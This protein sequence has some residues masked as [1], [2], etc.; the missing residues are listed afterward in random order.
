MENRILRYTLFLSTI[1]LFTFKVF[2]LPKS[3][4]TRYNFTCITM[5][6][7]LLHNFVDDIYKDKQG[8]LWISTSGGGLS[9][10]DGYEFMH[11]NIN[12]WPVSLK[13]NFIHKV[14]ED[15]FNRLWIISEKGTDVLNLSSQQL[16]HLTYKDKHFSQILN[17]PANTIL[18]DSKG[19][20]WLSAENTL[21]KIEFQQDG[22]VSNI[23]SLALRLPSSNNPLVALKEIN[24]EIWIGYNGNIYKVLANKSNQ[25][26]ISAVSDKLKLESGSYITAFFEK[27]NEVWIGT[28]HGL[29]RY[30]KTNE[31]LKRYIHSDNNPASL[32]QN[33]ITDLR[34]TTDRQL[35]VATLKGLNFYDPMNDNFMHINRD[36]KNECNSIN[37]DFINCL[38]TD[39]NLI[40][41]GT[42]A[43]G[44]NKMALRK[45]SIHNYIYNNNG[46][47]S[48]S[49]NPVNAI[50]EDNNR[51]LWVGT[52]EGGLNL[53]KKDNDKFIHF[54][55]GSSSLSHN[56]VSAI[57]ADNSNHLWIG[58][59]GGGINLL[60]LN[61][62]SH[63]TFQH[64]TSLT[65]PGFLVDFIGALCYDPINKGMWIGSNRGI[66]FY[67]TKSNKLLAPLPLKETKNI[68]GVIG[69]LIDKRNKLWM[70]TSEGAMIIDLNSFAKS[71]SHFSFRYLKYQNNKPYSHCVEK[72]NCLYESS[73]GTIWLGSNGYGLYKLISRKNE[74]YQFQSFTTTQGLTNNCVLGILEDERG[75][76]WLSTCNGLSCYNPKT[77]RF[78]NYTKEDGLISNQFYWNA[79]CKSRYNKLLYFGNI[80]GLIAIEGNKKLMTPSNEK[81]VFTKLS[82]LNETI[83]P[84]KGGYINTDISLANSLQL[85][86]SD[87]S[88]SL[89]FS[90]L[91]YENSNSITYSYRLLGFDDNW[92]K[93]S[94]NRRF[95]SYTSLRPGT[96]TLQ[97][98]CDTGSDI[99]SSNITELEIIVHPFFYKTTW[100]ICLMLVLLSFVIYRFYKWRIHTLKNQKELLHIK[101]EERTHELEEQKYLLEEQ[102]KELSRQNEMLKQ[103]NEKIT[104]QK[105]QLIKMSKKV[106]ELTLDKLTFFTNIT[107]EFRTPITL[108]MGPIERA[109]KLSYNPQVIEQLHFVERNSRHLLSLVNQLM[110][111]RKV[112]SGKIEIVKTPGNFRKFMDEILEP[113]EV[114]AHER[115]IRIEKRFRLSSPVIMFDEDAMNKVITNLLS[116]AIKYTPDKGVVTIYVS[117]LKDTETLKEKLLISVK[118]TG[119]GI[120]EEDISKIFNRFY[121]SKGSIKY[122]VYG[123]SSTGIGLYLC[124]QIV[125]LQGGIIQAKNNHTGGA[126]FRVLLPISREENGKKASEKM[127]ALP[128]PT[129][130]KQI[131]TSPEGRLNMLVVEDNKDMRSYIRSILT[132]HFNVF[133]AENGA[134]ALSILNLQNV[135]FIISD[136]MMPVMDGLELSRKVKE[137]FSISHIPFLMLTA[138]TSIE[139][140]IESFK[141]G[142]DEYLLKPFDED[143]LLARI[144][145][146]LENRKRYQK[147]FSFKMDIDILNVEEDS[148]DKKFLDKAMNLVKENFKNSYFE[149]SDFIESM[150]VSKSILN[151]K[152]QN[153]TGQSAG[154]F[155]RNYRL[156]IARELILKNRT[157]R[158]MNIS[159][160]AYEV[161]FNDPKYFTRCFTKHFIIT[162]SSLL[163]SENNSL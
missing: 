122:P 134:E 129:Q 66:Y 130:K 21:Y 153:L 68:Q 145:N 46:N 42:E 47:G 33:L 119:A 15:N 115:N 64:I 77:S 162:P 110:D 137:N 48:I 111:F 96:Y 135:D 44:L 121:Q 82:V 90:V 10:Y 138:K 136:L 80:E 84:G 91:N 100:F 81:V 86:E 37:C 52:V 159:E 75:R 83:Y 92:V 5:N 59:W 125:H 160:I 39:G 132:D 141:I 23:R 38:L 124:K 113:F 104:R 55:S 2:A 49:K 57:T 25:L 24:G 107:H 142:V 99:Q 149:V 69:S 20:I 126:S 74:E 161:G 94:S 65:H 54:T 127:T 34:E 144:N 105:G 146:I 16:N 79:Y 41:V 158:N 40:W 88:F 31:S 139:A 13:S 71:H 11:Y 116:N 14:C 22:S 143:L 60:D 133:E 72:I 76:L 58:T 102:T 12:T 151:K 148:C 109:L 114:F 51:N 9:R 157:T 101:V 36:E 128:S 97:V 85:H 32:S 8:F 18:K 156:N 19:N 131:V 1:F 87:K 6:D 56:S 43:G 93:V 26:V 163:E 53:K 120:S 62:I 123:Q 118:D 108:I 67:D 155:I 95:A 73:D 27:E 106:Q 7:G 35:L 150:G 63:P 4:I 152:M 112:E 3:L 29:F 28:D 50:Y 70:G 140:R 103:Q 147:Q 78:V 154:Q 17:R 89:E 117:S 45:L 98:K 61:N 30:N